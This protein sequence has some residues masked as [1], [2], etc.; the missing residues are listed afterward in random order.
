MGN[1]SDRLFRVYKYDPGGTAPVVPLAYFIE[2]TAPDDIDDEAVE[3]NPV[4][5][6]TLIPDP[7]DAIKEIACHL[8]KSPHPTL[9]INVHGY[10]TPR[11]AALERYK[12]SFDYVHD[13]PAITAADPVCIGYRWPSESLFSILWSWLRAA[14]LLLAGLLGV[15]LFLFACWAILRF[16]VHD[17]G[18]VPTLVVALAW[19]FAAFPIATWL[20]RGSVYYRDAWRAASYGA[21]DLVEIITQIDAR[22][23]GLAPDGV[24]PRRVALCVLGHSMGGFVVTNA[25]R[26][27]ADT[28]QP[29]AVPEGLNAGVA[30]RKLMR[31]E[32]VPESDD[33]A[34]AGGVREAPSSPGPDE[35]TFIPGDIGNSL[36]L[37][38]LVLVSPDIPAEAVI[39]NRANFL[40]SALRRCEEAYLFC[41][42]DDEV[43]RQLSTMSNSF[44]LPAKR[45]RYGFRLG[46]VEVVSENVAQAHRTAKPDPRAYLHDLRIGY[47]TLRRLYRKLNIGIVQNALPLVFSYFDCTDYNENGERFLSLVSRTVGRHGRLE[48]LS[49]F[50]HLRL[51]FSY[52]VLG[53]PD[54]HGGY[55]DP[56][57]KTANALMYRF[58]CLGYDATFAAFQKGGVPL[59]QACRNTGIQVLLSPYAGADAPRRR[60]LAS[61]PAALAERQRPAPAP[62]TPG[63]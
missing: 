4:P 59:L 33:D 28:F 14:P 25:L 7:D 1:G 15:S 16:L 52:L 45:W 58:L 43:L 13:D 11:K 61:A 30:K 36:R 12:A 60:E 23:T 37:V 47:F 27:L 46:N 48:T 40:E 62:A 26:V 51:L 24:P 63:E 35:L 22:L 56:R 10:N 44:T 18:W 20:L 3:P 32:D 6:L 34:P 31:A 53:S 57:A 49:S 17:T 54:V 9:A 21:P 55:F 8:R 19:I 38:R 2:S 42:G 5:G 50:Q 29:Q 39:S 41:S